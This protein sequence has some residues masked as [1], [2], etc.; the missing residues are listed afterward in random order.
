MRSHDDPLSIDFCSDLT[1]L[2]MN[3]AM[4]DDELMWNIAR[5][6]GFDQ[7]F[8]LF[9]SGRKCLFFEVLWKVASDD[10]RADSRHDCHDMQDAFT[11]LCLSDHFGRSHL[12]R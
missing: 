9:V 5:H 2:L 12:P 8:K 7:D 11:L 6:V 10:V 4:S 3:T 1:S